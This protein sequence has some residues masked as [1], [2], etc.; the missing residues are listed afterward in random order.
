V[1]PCPAELLT[2]HGQQH[3]QW[4]DN[5]EGRSE[6]LDGPGGAW[7]CF[8]PGR[9]A[10]AYIV[11]PDV[12]YFDYAAREVA[13]STGRGERALRVAARGLSAV[14]GLGEVAY[15][16]N[17]LLSTNPPLQV[18]DHEGAL[19]ALADRHPRRLV[20]GVGYLGGDLEPREA[21]RQGLA[22]Y[23]QVYVAP[24]SS[25]GFRR[26]TNLKRDLA[27]LRRRPLAVEAPATL[28]EQDAARVAALYRALYVGR[29]FDGNIHYT[30]AWFAK[31]A[32]TGA[33]EFVLMR[34]DGEVVGFVSYYRSGPYLVGA[35]LGHDMA[36]EGQLPVYRLLV[37]WLF[38]VA[39]E[40]G[41]DLHLSSGAGHFKQLRGGV[42]Q[43]E[44]LRGVSQR[45]A[46]MRRFDRL[47]RAAARLG[48][49]IGHAMEGS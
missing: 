20:L 27:L 43:I 38:Q 21:A 36:L 46:L 17:A 30:A 13:R 16:N 42:P 34:R 39:L 25:P 23:R 35:Y 2:L 41:R 3:Q 32:E 12:H 6:V 45:P 1:S 31:A 10:G 40:E 28:T 8:V 37:A 5:I 44:W 9:G 18:G 24:T 33:L 48:P 47:A 22:Y 29:Y 49:R 19:A 4:I 26:R 7:P 11:N 15:F 14:L